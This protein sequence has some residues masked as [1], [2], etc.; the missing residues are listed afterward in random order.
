MKETTPAVAWHGLQRIPNHPNGG[1]R[2]LLARVSS[3]WIEGTCYVDTLQVWFPAYW[4]PV[5]LQQLQKKK[6][7]YCA[8]NPS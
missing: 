7:R 5:V 4:A 3:D 6:D 1:S 2:R 8:E